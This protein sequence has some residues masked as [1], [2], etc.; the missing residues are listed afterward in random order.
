M[1]MFHELHA[2]GPPWRSSFWVSYLQ[3]SLVVR[4]AESADTCVTNLKRY[5]IW[6]ERR[7]PRHQI[8]TIPV[9]S[10]V[11][12]LADDTFIGDRK[13][14][15]IVFGGA[16][17]VK[18]LFGKYRA[19]TAACCK[20]FEIEKIMTVGSPLGSAP[21]NLPIGVRELGYLGDVDIADIMKS[22]RV[23]MMNYFPGYLA[24]SGVYAAYSALGLVPILPKSNPS[25]A[26][27]CI[28]GKT[29]LTANGIAGRVPHEL[30]EDIV[31]NARKWY[32]THSVARTANLY[33]DLIRRSI[34]R[35]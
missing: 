21:N 35:C 17:W 7:V 26:D 15:M 10:N 6:L 28:E 33:S 31:G 14:I 32:E 27:G 22:S 13:P 9:F 12:E 30:L 18:E 5:A 8:K 19:E 23:G 20:A 1:I 25:S 4:L 16:R 29:Y 24:K 34:A 3:K 11:G 2:F